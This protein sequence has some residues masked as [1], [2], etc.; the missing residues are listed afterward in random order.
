[1]CASC[2]LFASVAGE[3]VGSDPAFTQRDSREI[4]VLWLW[5]C[6]VGQPNGFGVVGS[7]G[8]LWIMRSLTMVKGRP[9]HWQLMY[10]NQYHHFYRIL[11]EQYSAVRVIPELTRPFAPRFPY[12]APSGEVRYCSPV[13]R[14]W[15]T[16]LS[17]VPLP[18]RWVGETEAKPR[19]AFRLFTIP[20]GVL[21]AVCMMYHPPRRDS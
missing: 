20:P 3:R 11:S 12:A 10:L 1:M 13:Q 4:L 2:V 17:C 5:W 14:C 9:A 16:C 18:G 15:A 7:C 21:D 19:I 6:R 8:R